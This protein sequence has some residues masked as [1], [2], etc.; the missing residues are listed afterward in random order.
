MGDKMLWALHTH[1][2]THGKYPANREPNA[3]ETRQDPH[4][5][6]ESLKFRRAEAEMRLA[7]WQGGGK[8]PP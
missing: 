3:A 8:E 2:R 1:R 7:G 4:P 6:S 5:R